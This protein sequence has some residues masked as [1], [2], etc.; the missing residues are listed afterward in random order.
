[1]E[2]TVNLMIFWA[3]NEN[4]GIL[5]KTKKFFCTDVIQIYFLMQNIFKMLYYYNRKE[6]QK[7]L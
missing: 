2:H 1:M 6:M 4:L 3:A 7:S 5:T